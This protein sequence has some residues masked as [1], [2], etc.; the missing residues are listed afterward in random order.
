MN[1]QYLKDNAHRHKSEKILDKFLYKEEKVI[2]FII[3][4]VLQKDCE[5]L[6]KKLKHWEKI[7]E[8]NEARLQKKRVREQQDK[9]EELT[10]NENEE[11]KPSKLQKN[12][13]QSLEK[14]NKLKDSNT[15]EQEQNYK[16][17]DFSQK[18]DKIL[19]H[20]PQEN[21]YNKCLN[22]LKEVLMNLKDIPIIVI[23]KILYSII[24][25]DMKFKE[26]NDRKLIIG[27]Y[28]STY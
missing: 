18:I 8:V 13:E 22:L 9:L 12:N 11:K 26:V 7:E 6:N 1:A 10:K 19:K 14:T 2:N 15:S 21:K 23:I 4:L 16:I 27:N 28:N 20:L 17:D 24:R 3:M 25:I 5:E